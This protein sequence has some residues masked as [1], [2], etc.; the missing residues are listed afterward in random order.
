MPRPTAATPKCEVGETRQAATE[1][2]RVDE[3]V[4]EDFDAQYIPMLMCGVCAAIDKR[5]VGSRWGR[6]LEM[7]ISGMRRTP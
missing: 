4:R 5:E 6:H 3:L 1:C 2:G 7:V